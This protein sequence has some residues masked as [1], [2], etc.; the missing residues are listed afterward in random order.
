METIKTIG[1][2]PG[3]DDPI[4]HLKPAIDPAGLVH[5]ELLDG[6]FWQRIPAYHEVDEATFLP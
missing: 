5:T 3:P 6:P 1:R 4:Q 2:A